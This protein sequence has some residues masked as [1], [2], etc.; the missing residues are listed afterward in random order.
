MIISLE[1]VKSFGRISHDDDD[2]ELSMFLDAAIEYLKNATG[3]NFKST[4]NLAKLYLKVWV[5]ARYENRI[6][7]DKAQNTLRSIMIQLQN[8]Y[9]VDE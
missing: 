8:S 4:N 3:I 1:E 7:D 9:G 6:N 5:M 2:V